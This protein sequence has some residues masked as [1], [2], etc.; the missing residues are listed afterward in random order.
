MATRRSRPNS[1]YKR[2]IIGVG[3]MLL[4]LVGLAVGAFVSLESAINAIE[5]TENQALEDL[6]PISNLETLILETSALTQTY[7]SQGGTTEYERFLRL[8]RQ[9]DHALQSIVKVPNDL[10]ERRSL[11]QTTLQEWEK[12]LSLSETIFARPYPK[13][14][15]RTIQ[16]D[17]KELNKHTDQ[18]IKSL[19]QL[20]NLVLQFQ[21]SDNLAQAKR[22][23]QRVRLI[24]ATVF[25]LGL[26]LA[27][28]AGWLL[29]RSIL[30]PL[31]VLEKGVNRLGEGE[32][33]HRI[34]LA[35]Q[36]ELEH[37]A[38]TFNAMAA[39]LEQNQV[40]LQAQ[41]TLDGLTG[42]YNRH[43]FNL[44]FTAELEQAQAQDYPCSLIMADIDHFKR[45]N[46][47]YGHQ[48][49]D[50]AIRFVAA[51]L[52][53]E[54]RQGDLVARYGGEEFAIILPHSLGT[55]AQAVAE[56]IRSAIAH[57]AI[58]VL[59]EQAIHITMSFGV[60]TLPTDANSENS[61]LAAADQA[62][63]HAKHTG[64][65]RVCQAPQMSQSVAMPQ[66]SAA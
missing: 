66:Q 50:E 37:L 38:K 29:S 61:L 47:T 13:G 55:E 56:R 53:Q 4:P 15:V 16:Q 17:R 19:K 31:A 36:D 63:Y 62:L 46:D 10:P 54:I 41:A 52:K 35:T 59:P 5:T 26:I 28:I 40:A 8:R 6:F 44:R 60:A 42:I 22:V 45:I 57:K 39:K 14:D 27:A 49:G 25:G 43:E 12:V 48:G 51:I 21:V 11:L 20:N 58:S 1:L 65:N 23:K 3:T 9:A 2:F 18:A 32:L 33:S 24:I 34:H 30:R 64:R 7:L